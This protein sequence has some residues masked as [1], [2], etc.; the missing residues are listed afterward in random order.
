VTTSTV[1]ARTARKPHR[2][3]SCHW[4]ASLRGV[5]TI[6]P[7]H[8]YLRHVAF[9]GHEVNQS[10][11]PPYVSTECVACAC[12]RDD[13]AGLLLAGAC[14]TFCCGDIPCARPFRHGAEHSCRRCSAEVPN[15]RP[16]TAPTA[17][18]VGRV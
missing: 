14:S 16:A 10:S 18:V 17:V 9:P 2:C 1:E 11:R 8:R 13:T 5:A 12:E 7:G 3:D 4:N 6:A 15:G